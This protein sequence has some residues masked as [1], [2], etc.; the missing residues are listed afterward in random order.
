MAGASLNQVTLIGRLTRDPECRTF[1]NG[2][3]VANF[4]LA[5]NERQKSASGEWVDAALFLD[6]SAFNRG[7]KGTLANIVEQYCRKGGLICVVGKLTEDKWE[8]K[9][10]GQKR[11]KIKIVADTI[12]LLGS[13]ADG[14]Q[15]EGPPQDKYQQQ[16]QEEQTA[17][18]E[19]QSNNEEIIPF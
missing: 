13:K 2:G 19:S 16:Q 3:K 9:T 4:G 15:R 12:Q 17:A 8:D 1:A 18:P 11:S 14:E 6:V 10:T 7:D 5:I